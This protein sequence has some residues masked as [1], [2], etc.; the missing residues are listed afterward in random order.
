[1]VASILHT[2]LL[3]YSMYYFDQ[4]GAKTEVVEQRLIDLISTN[5]DP[6][7]KMLFSE[8]FLFDIIKQLVSKYKSRT[9]KLLLNAKIREKIL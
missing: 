7:K 3:N 9:N 6:D 8:D 4:K 1:M 2:R 5:D